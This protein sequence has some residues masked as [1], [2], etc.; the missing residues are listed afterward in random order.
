[1]LAQGSPLSRKSSQGLPGW[2]Q[3]SPQHGP[4]LVLFRKGKGNQKLAHKTYLNLVSSRS[5]DLHL[6]SLSPPHIC[7][8]ARTHMCTHAYTCILTFTH[9]YTF[10]YFHIHSHAHIHSHTG[11]AHPLGAAPLASEAFPTRCMPGVGREGH[12]ESGASEEPRWL[13]LGPLERVSDIWPVCLS[14]G[15]VTKGWTLP[16]QKMQG[17]C[18]GSSGHRSLSLSSG[19]VLTCPSECPHFSQGQQQRLGQK[20]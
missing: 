5:A 18:T 1:M 13:M 6:P 4:Y 14:Q 11:T 3:W 20:V 2:W 16:T 9:T 12:L 19:I 17:Q 8:C 15:L 10:A 7:A